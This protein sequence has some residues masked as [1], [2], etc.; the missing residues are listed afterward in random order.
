MIQNLSPE[1][2]YSLV[3]FRGSVLLD[4]INPLADAFTRSWSNG[5]LTRRASWS[6]LDTVT[7]VLSPQQVIN[8]EPA[9][10]VPGQGVGDAAARFP[11]R[12]P[13]VAVAPSVSSVSTTAI[14]HLLAVS[15][16]PASS[17]PHT[18]VIRD[19]IVVSALAAM[20]PEARVAAK[21]TGVAVVTLPA[22]LNHMLTALAVPL[23][24]PSYHERPTPGQRKEFGRFRSRLWVL[25]GNLVQYDPVAAGAVRTAVLSREATRKRKAATA[26][27]SAPVDGDA[28]VAALASWPE[29]SHAAAP[30]ASPSFHPPP[31]LASYASP[32]FAP[33]AFSYPSLPSLASVH[34]PSDGTMGPPPMFFSPPP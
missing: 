13:S 6:L 23:G 16:G 8:Y 20:T 4:D 30:A 31:L 25:A 15:L 3:L 18:E 26:I 10:I 11:C 14:A 27:A 17:A 32:P 33:L 28:I 21:V 29:A 1:S 9:V 24:T 19:S 34:Q 7:D 12:G 5:Y 2:R 22:S